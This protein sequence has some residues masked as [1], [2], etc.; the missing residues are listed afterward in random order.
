MGACVGTVCELLGR[1][2][3]F[4]LGSEQT[5]LDL[6]RFLPPAS[7]SHSLQRGGQ[8]MATWWASE[9]WASASVLFFFMVK[10]ESFFL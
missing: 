4:R 2:A 9:G 7:S 6:F 8:P 5:D 3:P 1:P 10:E